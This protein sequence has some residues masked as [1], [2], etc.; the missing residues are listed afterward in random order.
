MKNFRAF[1]GWQQLRR[2]GAAALVVAGL[3][4]APLSAEAQ[5]IVMAGNYQN[6]DVLNNT[7]GTV[8]GFEMEVYGVSKSQ[9]TRIFPS[10]FPNLNVIRY[11]VGTATDFPGGVRVRWSANYDAATGTY[12]TATGTPPSLTS[13]PGDSCWRPGMPGLYDTAGCEHFGISTAYV[14]PL[15]INY[16]WLIDDPANHGSLIANSTYI[17][18]PAPVWVALPPANP[19]LP[20]V[21]VAEI[22]APPAPPAR[23][24]DAQWVKVY[25]IEQPGWRQSCRC[26][27][28]RGAAGNQ[29]VA[30]AGRPG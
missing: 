10:N 20:P 6:F 16:Y 24:G 25:K 21:V 18:L 5:S 14:N 4:L 17:N 11:G 7:G 8:Y 2:L 19:A 27:R 26:A 22:P 29:L 30:A 1:D 28:E 15:R 3:A 23:F 9:L 13:V 12:S